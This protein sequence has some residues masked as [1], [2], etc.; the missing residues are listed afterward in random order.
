MG[1]PYRHGPKPPY[2]RIETLSPLV[3]RIVAHNPSPFTYHGTGTFVV[4]HGKVAIIDAGP[5]QAQHVSAL[6][7]ALSGEEVTHQFVTHTHRDH[8]PASAPVRERTGARTHAYGPHG[9]GQYERGARVEA[10]ADF[11]FRPDVELRHGDVVEGDGWSIEAIYT[12]GHCSNHM[13]FQLREEKT[14]FTGDHVMGWSTSV[15][16]PPDGDMSDYMASL[17]LLLARDD[18]L[19]RP[20]HGPPIEDPKPFVRAFIEHRQDRQAQILQCL[21]Q[22]MDSIDGMVEQIYR[23]VPKVLHGAAARSVFAHLLH[24]LQEGSVVTEGPPRLS[25]RYRLK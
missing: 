9:E 7:E 14:L 12:P 19:Y 8:S 5:E 23:D 3:R 25:A 20:T 16:S 13:C 15:I 18:Q 17:A 11:D 2:G 22:G 1:I 24:L 4:G 10:G 6:L 21:E